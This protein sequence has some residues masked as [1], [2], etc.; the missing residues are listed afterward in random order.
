MIHNIQEQ[1]IYVKYVLLWSNMAENPNFPT[2]FSEILQRRISK[3]I[4]MFQRWLFHVL[5]PVL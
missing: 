2:A 4:Q 1:F 5:I 3:T